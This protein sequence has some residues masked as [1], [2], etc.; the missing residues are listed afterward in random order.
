MWFNQRLCRTVA[1]SAHGQEVSS[2]WT[3]GRKGTY[4]QEKCMRIICR[5]SPKQSK[6]SLCPYAVFTNSTTASQGLEWKTAFSK[7]KVKLYLSCRM[8]HPQHHTVKSNNQG[9]QTNREAVRPLQNVSKVEV[10]DVWS[11]NGSTYSIW[12]SSI[13]IQAYP[14]HIPR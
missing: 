13:Q 10:A 3:C 1:T 11:E 9:K 8:P 14:D 5:I 12:R 7:N 2:G 4:C 6:A